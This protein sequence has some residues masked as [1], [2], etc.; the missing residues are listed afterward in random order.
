MIFRLLIIFFLLPLFAEAQQV[1]T[2]EDCLRHAQEHNLSIKQAELNATL[3]KDALTQSKLS[4]L[5]SLNG[6]ASNSYNFGRNID[7]YTNTFTVDRVRTNNF[8]L[9][10]GMTLFNGFQNIN[11]IRKSNY[12]YLASQY[13]AEKVA[14]DV[15]V[16]LVTAYLQLMYNKELVAVQTD[17]QLLSQLQVDR[18]AKMVE[19]GRLP[20]GNLLETESQMAQE[21]LQL[22]NAQNQVDIAVLNI[23][24]L[25]DLSATTPFDI[26]SPSVVVEANKLVVGLEE[27]YAAA[28]TNLPDIKSASTKVSSAERS[29]AMAQGGRAPRLSLSGS[30]GTGYS[31]ARE[32]IA[33]IDTLNGDII[34]TEY[35]FDDQLDDNL[36]QSLSFSLSLPI[37]NAWQANNSVSRA[38]IG[39]LQSKYNLQEAENRLRKQIEQ[40]YAD[41][42]AAHKK[43]LASTKSVEALSE[44]FRYIE[45]KYEVELVSTYE[46][47]DAKNNLFQAEADLL[48]AKY[49]FIFKRKMMDFYMGNELKF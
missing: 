12:D 11:N 2:L 42:L 18:I 47:N 43:Y 19:V 17:K 46:Y 44:S 30:V 14:N 8:G 16:N 49:D 23:K 3:S 25:L 36:S 24:Q 9:S 48:Q 40:A 28:Y 34:Y 33:G 13:D 45:E 20:K 32:Q 29:L 37:F 27:V 15:S 35:P 1:W 21:E 38:K 39:L 5:P 41:A 22:I 10:S 31:D 6:T 7:P 4:L 26:V